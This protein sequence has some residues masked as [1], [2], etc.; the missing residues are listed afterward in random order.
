MSRELEMLDTES[1]AT[2]TIKDI[3]SGYRAHMI[4][5]LEML[6]TESLATLTIRDIGGGYRA[7][8]SR[9]PEMLNT[10]SLATPTIR[11]IGGRYRAH[12]SREPEMLNT[13]SLATPTIGVPSS[14]THMTHQLQSNKTAG[15]QNNRDTVFQDRAQGDKATALEIQDYKATGLQSYLQVLC[16]THL[17]GPPP[18]L[19]IHP[20]PLAD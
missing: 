1:Q 18:P 14:M 8:M 9:E 16:R 2:P 7:H 19:P 13:E 6:D 12:M 4:R 10:E 3:G 20:L 5:E 15:L 11:D 17:L